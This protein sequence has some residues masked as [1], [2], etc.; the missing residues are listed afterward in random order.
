MRNYISAN[1]FSFNGI[2]MLVLAT[3]FAGIVL[4][5]LLGFVGQ[6][7]FLVG[8]FPA[9]VGIAGGYVLAQAIKKFKMPNKAVAIL[10]G[11]LMAVMIYGSYTY[12]D[13]LQFQNQLYDAMVTFGDPTLYIFKDMDKATL[14]NFL[15]QETTGSTGLIG[16]WKSTVNAGISIISMGG[17]GSNFPFN[18]LWSTLYLISEFLLIAGF[19]IKGAWER[20]NRPFCSG[21]EAWYDEGKY[22]ASFEMQDED[23]VINAIERDRFDDLKNLMRAELSKPPCLVLKVHLCLNC[24]NEN[25]LLELSRLTVGDKGIPKYK[26]CLRGLITS[27]QLSELEDKLR[28]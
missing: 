9:L 5:L 15:L 19:A 16:Y 26:R 24:H 22:L 11:T 12:F 20:V 25:P 28:S 23:K 4:G 10:I 21:C 13:Y 1:E 2:V 18:P 7:F 6:F 3:I 14:T 27:S 17:M 8:I